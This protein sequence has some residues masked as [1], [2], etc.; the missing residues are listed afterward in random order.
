LLGIIG[1]SKFA[2]HPASG[3]S[4]PPQAPRTTAELEADP[5]LQY[6]I[7]ILLYDLTHLSKEPPSERRISCT[8]DKLYISIPYLSPDEACCVKS[9]LVDH[10]SGHTSPDTTLQNWNSGRKQLA[11]QSSLISPTS[12]KSAERLDMPGHAVLTTWHRYTLIF[13]GFG[14]RNLRTKIFSQDYGD[15]DC[16][17]QHSTGIKPGIKGS[18]RNWGSRE[19][20]VTKV[21]LSEQKYTRESYCL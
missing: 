2:K 3:S 9:A 20:D 10:G 19:R 5:T 12:S 16:L 15:K 11:M 21:G 18:E 17:R 7:K 1:K 14:K 13:L 6:K 8:I 4:Q